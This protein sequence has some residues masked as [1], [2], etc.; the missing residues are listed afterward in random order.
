MIPIDLFDMH[1]FDAQPSGAASSTEWD[2]TDFG[3]RGTADQEGAEQAED[4]QNKTA[5][6]PD[7][8]AVSAANRSRS[9]QA[10]T[11]VELSAS[12]GALQPV[13]E[14]RNYPLGDQS[15]PKLP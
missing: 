9:E 6:D 15:Q 12:T 11:P 5:H 8:D 2:S 13:S 1:L 7:A 10:Q 14:A 4:A 3:D